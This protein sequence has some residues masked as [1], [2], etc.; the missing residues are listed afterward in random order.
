MAEAIA[1]AAERLRSPGAAWPTPR[2]AAAAAAAAQRLA[3]RG[4]PARVAAAAGWRQAYGAACGPLALAGARA[5]PTPL[6]SL[7]A[8][9]GGAACALRREGALLQAAWD[10]TAL[11]AAVTLFLRAAGEDAQL[12][13][14]WLRALAARRDAPPLLLCA[15]GAAEAMAGHPAV[16][17]RA[18]ARAALAR[19]DAAPAAAAAALPCDADCGLAWAEESGAAVVGGEARAAAAAALFAAEALCAAAARAALARAEAEAAAAGAPSALAAG[20]GSHLQL[21]LARA[22][23]PAERA[24]RAPAHPALDAFPA[25][26]VAARAAESEA[27]FFASKLLLGALRGG[28]EVDSACATA[29]AAAVRLARLA[30][31]RDRVTE[32]LSS[33]PAASPPPVEPLLHAWLRLRKPLRALAAAAADGGA[34]AHACG[35]LDAAWGLGALGAPKPLLWRGA[36]HPLPPADPS[37]T[38]MEARL[39]ALAEAGTPRP[40]AL[41]LALAQAA[42]LLALAAGGALGAAEAAALAQLSEERCAAA[43]ATAEAEEA[44]GAVEVASLARAAPAEE[45]LAFPFRLQRFALA[46]AA[47]AELRAAARA[48]GLRAA[49]ALLSRPSDADAQATLLAFS[50]AASDL[51]PLDAAPLQTLLWLRERGA[52]AAEAGDAALLGA[53][54]ELAYRTLR[55]AAGSAPPPDGPAWAAGAVGALFRPALAA[56]L[57]GWAEATERCPAAGAAARR[58]QLRL[59][60]RLARGG[61]SLGA[62]PAGRAEQAAAAEDDVDALHC[63]AEALL[64]AL[65][66]RWP[67]LA[68]AADADAPPTQLALAGEGGLEAAALLTPL[69]ASLS[70]ARAERALA[71]GSPA[72]EAARGAAWARLGAARLA[73]LC[74]ELTADPAMRSALKRD[75]LLAAAAESLAP[76]ARAARASAALPGASADARACARAEAELG[77]AEAAAERHGRAA[78]PRPQ[79]SDWP[80]IH[81]ELRRFA[82]GLGCVP[83]PQPR[84]HCLAPCATRGRNF[85]RALPRDTSK[86]PTHSERCVRAPAPCRGE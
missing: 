40:P 8:V 70:A 6:P 72:C 76:A 51:S 18:E 21:A 2:E 1:A 58:L 11:R 53:S 47:A 41:R 83:A 61:G 20:G 71:P 82:D 25:A 26:L 32:L 52:E 56:A 9:A 28:G 17:A 45:R 73:L 84:P 66:P 85:G 14:L 79:P 12:R 54:H 75:R 10:A 22:A 39:R 37:V 62:R 19:A 80:A 16:A 63:A 46:A 24:R 31:W 29:A 38:P 15:A 44:P 27:C 81:A 64:R 7:G 86:P 69:L 42:A 30:G 13:A 59:A 3:A 77:A 57:L 67:P 48:A 55:A 4:W 23:A 35:V 36:G 49:L 34:W 78:V 50:A 65:A 68:A 74:A 33:A 5:P 60:L 43:A